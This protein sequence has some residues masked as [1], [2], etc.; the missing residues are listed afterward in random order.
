M[1][2]AALRCM[3][4]R[5]ATAYSGDCAMMRNDAKHHVS[6]VLHAG[7]CGNATTHAIGLRCQSPLAKSVPWSVALS[8]VLLYC[9]RSKAAG[10]LRAVPSVLCLALYLMQLA[11]VRRCRSEMNVAPH[12]YWTSL[13]ISTADQS[14]P[15]STVYLVPSIAIGAKLASGLFATHLIWRYRGSRR[16]CADLTCPGYRKLETEGV[17]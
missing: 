9:R 14:S 5:Y 12:R 6:G 13:L 17:F 2:A 10:P 7:A 3:Q 11:A 15:G 1:H 16:S 4:K 8:I